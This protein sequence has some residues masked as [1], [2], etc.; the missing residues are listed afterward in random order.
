MV[1]DGEEFLRR[2]RQEVE[3]VVHRAVGRRMPVAMRRLPRLCRHGDVHLV[4]DAARHQSWDGVGAPSVVVVAENPRRLDA[5]PRQRVIDL[6]KQLTEARRRVLAARVAIEEARPGRQRVGRPFRLA[7]LPQGAH[8]RPAV[9]RQGTQAEGHARHVAGLVQ[10]VDEDEV[11][12]LA[13]ET[14]AVVESEAEEGRHGLRQD[15]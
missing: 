14:S 15:R 10:H 5:E 2:A 4:G 8:A 12:G 3:G 11:P 9:G 1:V 13:P 6:A 7:V